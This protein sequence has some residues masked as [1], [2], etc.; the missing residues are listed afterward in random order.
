[1]TATDR[2]GG[3]GRER[4]RHWREPCVCDARLLH[5]TGESPCTVIDLSPG[6]AKVRTDEPL[7][8]YQEVTLKMTQ[9]GAFAGE[10]AWVGSD[11]VGLH[12]THHPLA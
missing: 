7:R 10:V 5:K 2:P 11:S 12:F 9:E 1:M 6:G 4:R 8:A 3:P